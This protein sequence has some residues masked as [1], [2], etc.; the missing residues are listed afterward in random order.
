MGIITNLYLYILL[1]N[2][3]K[4][5]EYTKLKNCIKQFFQTDELEFSKSFYPG[6]PM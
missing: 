6:M 2:M 5:R 4:D 3:E 1:N